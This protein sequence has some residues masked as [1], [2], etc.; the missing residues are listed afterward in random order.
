MSAA[1]ATAVANPN[2]AFVKYWGNADPVL[3]L[4]ANPSISMN[5]DSLSTVTTVVFLAEQEADEAIINDA[6]VSD[7]TLRR[8]TAHLDQVRALAG[9][10]LRARVVSRSNFPA[11][12]GL[13]SSASAFAAL[14][15]AAAAAL[16]LT[17]TE[18]ALSSL[19]RLGSGSAC[20]SIPPGF[21]EWVAGE[22][23][24]ASFARSIAPPGHWPLC[25]CIAIVSTAH[26]GVGSTEGHA[27]ALSSPLYHTRVEGA[28]ARVAACRTAILARDLPALGKAMETDT[29]MMHAVTM[30]SCPPVYYWAPATLHVVR[31]VVAWRA[32]GLPVYYTVDAGPNVHCLCEEAHAAEISQLLEALPNVQQVRIARPGWGTR[33]VSEH[34]I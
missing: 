32:E 6:P 14:T 15:L 11:G 20:R 34:L 21:V 33:L 28:S 13:A 9:T 31:A 2:I 19:A 18:E 3:H 1:K 23:H 5:L 10:K 17:L 16:R 26:K 7:T 30:T 24:E 29:V 22:S 8:V 4:P 27:R 12:A 25:D